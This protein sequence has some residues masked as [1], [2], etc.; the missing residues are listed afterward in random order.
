MTMLNFPIPEAAAPDADGELVAELEWSVASACNDDY[1]AARSDLRLR[2]VRRCEAMRAASSRIAALKAE[3]AE[4]RAT[5][6]HIQGG[7]ARRRKAEAGLVVRMNDF[8]RSASQEMLDAMRD[9][10]AS[11][12]NPAVRAAILGGFM[13]GWQ[14]GAVLTDAGRE[15]LKAVALAIEAAATIIAALKPKEQG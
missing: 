14:T 1:T 7:I 3:V 5:L 11:Q 12:L 8:A 13:R 4:L 6:E 15:Y 9:D 2:H 10:D